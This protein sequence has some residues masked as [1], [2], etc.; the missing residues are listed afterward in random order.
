MESG[1]WRVFLILVITS[2]LILDM[3]N[4]NIHPS[5]MSVPPIGIIHIRLNK[6]DTYTVHS[7]LNKLPRVL[8]RLS[9]RSPH[10]S[11]DDFHENY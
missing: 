2:V 7:E 10:H 6:W 11:G 8:G 9:F 3:K 5:V 1:P 4:L